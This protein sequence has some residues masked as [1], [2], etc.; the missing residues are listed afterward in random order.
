MEAPQFKREK[1]PLSGLHRDTFPGDLHDDAFVCH[2][3]GHGSA[4]STPV[5][6]HL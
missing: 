2:D 4:A 1:G 5:C 3:L 6:D